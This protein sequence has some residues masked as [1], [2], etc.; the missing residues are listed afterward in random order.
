MIIFGAGEFAAVMLRKLGGVPMVN[1]GYEGSVSV[2]GRGELG[3]L[4]YEEYI[5]E[6]EW[7][8]DHIVDTNVL[9]AMGP[10]NGNRDR[11]R[12]FEQ[13][14]KGPLIVNTYR[15]PDALIDGFVDTGCVIFEQNNLQQCSIGQNVVLWSGNHVG[16]GSRIGA[17]SFITSH[18]CIGG[19]AV[20]GERCYIGMN[21]TV[22]DHVTIG[23][24]CVIAAGAVVDRDIPAGHMLSRKGI[25]VPNVAQAS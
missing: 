3:A 17:H 6:Q 14:M 7:L 22:F 19:G 21:A 20:I 11:Q 4:I 24:D 23:N 2:P 13:L 18:V 10:A 15:S 9:M 12:V 25:L 16:H 1:K 5:K 8:G